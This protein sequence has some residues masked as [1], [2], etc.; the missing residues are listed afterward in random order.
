MLLLSLV[1][2]LL[3]GVVFFGGLQWTVVRGLRSGAPAIW[4]LS[5]ALL[6]MSICVGGIYFVSRG[7][8]QR[9]LVCLLGL[10]AAREAVLRWPRLMRVAP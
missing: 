4:F 9:S 1:T 5:S 7:S 3:L 6:R 8:W 2:G 10:V